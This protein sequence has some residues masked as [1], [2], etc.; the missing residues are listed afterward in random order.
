MRARQRLCER[1]WVGGDDV[2]FHV[3]CWRF[4]V[5]EGE[6]RGKQMR[7]LPWLSLFG[8]QMSWSDLTD[9]TSGEQ[10]G[11]APQIFGRNQKLSLIFNK[12]T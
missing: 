8:F 1:V 12:E 2:D 5:L 4:G 6:V 11:M 10:T 3:V 9:R 7:L